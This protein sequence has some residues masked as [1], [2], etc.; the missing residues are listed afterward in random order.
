MN[1]ANFDWGWLAQNNTNVS[2]FSTEIF[3]DDTYQRFFKVDHGDT[4]LDIGASVGPFAT[5]IADRKPGR[6]ICIEPDK[7]SVPTL[8]SN[9]AKLD[10]KT[11]VIDRAITDTDGP[12]QIRGL[13][14]PTTDLMWSYEVDSKADVEGITFKTLLNDYNISRID[15]LKIDCEGNEYDVFNDENLDWIKKN[16]R[17]AA[18]EWHLHTLTHKAKFMRFRDT[19]LKEFSNFKILAMNDVDI[20]H[21]LWNDG[22][23]EYYAMIQIYID[24]TAAVPSTKLQKWSTTPWPTLEITTNIPPKGCVVDC[25][26]CPQRTLVGAYDGEKLLSFE[27]FKYVIDR[28]PKDIRITFAGFTEPWLNPR[29]TDMLLYAYEQG[30]RIAA[31]TTG[32]GMKVEDVDRIKHVIY[33]D[34]PNAGLVL[35]LPDEEYLAKHPITPRYLEVVKRFHD[36]KDEVN[37][38]QIMC[39]GE[40]HPKVQEYFPSAPIPSMW[41]RAGN[42]LGEAVLKPELMNVF[43]RVQTIYTGEDPMTCDQYERLYH[44]VLIP[45]GDVSLCCMDYNLE[46]IIGN[47]FEQEYNEILPIPFSTFDMCRRCESGCSP[48]LEKFNQEKEEI[49]L[50]S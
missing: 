18:G 12:T 30:H 48:D 24:N 19:Y 39:M 25:I 9:L 28:L 44:N 20:T 11:V 34:G 50:K 49:L 5:K 1:T 8:R 13:I 36:V 32:V 22:F 16:V 41:H 45:S 2:R 23:I 35:H 33:D 21:E 43:D 17:K 40:V 3:D 26:F 15:F 46:E 6:I 4:V 47:L 14:D 31:F 38:F 42:L 27:R 37:N 7:R 10:C 29:A